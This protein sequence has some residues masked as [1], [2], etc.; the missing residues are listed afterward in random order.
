MLYLG[1]EPRVTGGYAQT[2]PLSYGGPADIFL[3][4]IFKCLLSL[5][6]SLGSTVCAKKRLSVIGA[7]I[8]VV[9]CSS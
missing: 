3:L 7:V 2:N 5:I 9:E 4:L 1:L 8:N 6:L